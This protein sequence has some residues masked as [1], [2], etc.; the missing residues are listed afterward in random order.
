MSDC[1]N[2]CV[3]CA[4]AP[5]AQACAAWQ[6][7][8][9][10]CIVAASS[11]RI[12]NSGLQEEEESRQKRVSVLV[13]GVVSASVCASLSFQ[14]LCAVAASGNGGIPPSRFPWEQVMTPEQDEPKQ[15]TCS[16]CIGV[17]DDTLGSCSATTNCVSSFD[18]RFVSVPCESWNSS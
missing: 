6:R 17:V 2:I 18:D 11:P 16:T 8:R 3:T 7:H 13:A 9:Q 10:S 14:G 12:A 4:M 15:G 1:G 5:A